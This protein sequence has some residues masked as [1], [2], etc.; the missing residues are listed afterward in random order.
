[1]RVGWAGGAPLSTPPVYVLDTLDGAMSPPLLLSY[2]GSMG[3]AERVLIDFA[4]GLEG[5]PWLACPEGPLADAGRRAGLHVWPLRE[6]S[7]ALRADRV[8]ALTRLAAH[9]REV[10]ALVG[11]LEPEL[12]VANGTRS[13]LALL[14]PRPPRDAPSIVFLQHDLLPGPWIG[15]LVRSA[16]RRSSLVV[17]PSRTVAFDLG[18]RVPAVVVHPGVE[19]GRF[20]PDVAPAEPPVVLVLGALVGWKQPQLALEVLA[21]VRRERPEVRLRIVGAPIDP[22]GEEL[23]A[24]LRERAARP[25]LAGSVELPG[26]VPDPASELARASCLLHCAPRE[27]FGM[28]VIEALAAGRPVVAPA[29][30]GPQEILGED[31]PGLMYPPGDAPAAG[32]AVLRAL[33]EPDRRAA[34]RALASERFGSDAARE[35]F[36]LLVEPLVARRPSRPP[37]PLALVTVT[38]NSASELGALLRSAERHLP[39]VRVIVVDNASTDETLTVA[40]AAPNATVIEL[41]ENRGFGAGSNEGLRSVGEPVTALVN[42]DVELLDDSLLELAAE[43]EHSDRLLAPLVLSPDGSR[44]DT[45]HPLPAAAPELLRAL[46]PTRSLPGPLGEWVAPW[47]ARREREV[48][49]AVGCAIVARTETLRALGPFDERTF[50]YGEDL[51]LGLR[52]RAAG[53]Q[54][55]FWPSARVLHRGG[56][57]TSKAFGDEPFELLARARH[58]AVA[59]GLGERRARLDDQVQALTFRS[60]ITLKRALRL[61]AERE[62]RQ[63]AAVR[64]LP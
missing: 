48:G 50:L 20:D 39:G 35:R 46:L 57:A 28:V 13:A 31:G 47:R 12:V 33:S 4:S 1:M 24:A 30:A 16:A 29:S 7:T 6:R 58:D 62:R 60:R 59:R 10:R 5:G 64:R 38:H 49:W 53:V 27:P 41:G 25:D 21:L 55:W 37:A 63:L 56:H 45:V 3:G 15:A 11:D 8:G 43:A 42:P 17:V 26:A 34:S 52:A 23:L 54:T 22:A 51:E 32:R 19:L 61:D 14:W 18:P 40:R 9:R 2:S 44:Q 36:A